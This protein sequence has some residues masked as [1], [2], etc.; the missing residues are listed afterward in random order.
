MFS[1]FLL[2]YSDVFH[3]FLSRVLACFPLRCSW[4]SL[5]SGWRVAEVNFALCAVCDGREEEEYNYSKEQL[6][7]HCWQ[8]KGSE[9]R[10]REAMGGLW[11]TLPTAN[12]VNDERVGE[13]GQVVLS[14]PTL[15]T[16]FRTHA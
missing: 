4:R 16:H 5:H 9:E 2:V 10:E 11:M 3:C 15:H 7:A 8:G 12:S 13:Y 1:H 14:R 6:V